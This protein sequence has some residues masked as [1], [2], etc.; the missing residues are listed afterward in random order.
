MAHNIYALTRLETKLNIFGLGS[1]ENWLVL[2]WFLIAAKGERN[3]HIFYE[4]VKGAP[5]QMQQELGLNSP[6][7]FFYLSQSKCTTVDGVD[8][9]KGFEDVC[10]AMNVIEV[11]QSDQVSWDFGSDPKN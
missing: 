11:S 4:L 3:F 8:D 5:P 1:Q 6:E 7:S 2:I 10:K 9:A